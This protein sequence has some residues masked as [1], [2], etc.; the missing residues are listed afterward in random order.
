M[1]RILEDL[2]LLGKKVPTHWNPVALASQEKVLHVQ[3]NISLEYSCF[4]LLK[5]WKKRIIKGNL[6]GTIFAYDCHMQLL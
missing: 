5:V 6:D 1:Q 4:N 3:K 2:V